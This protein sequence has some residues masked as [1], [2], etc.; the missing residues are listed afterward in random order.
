[1]AGSD[2]TSAQAKPS[3]VV[4]ALDGCQRFRALRG[5]WASATSPQ[6]IRGGRAQTS[7]GRS[8]NP[9]D[10]SGRTVPIH[11]SHTTVVSGS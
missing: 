1:M 5:G 8:E 11:P 10:A 4:R 3:A 7:A 6:P 2:S 9:S